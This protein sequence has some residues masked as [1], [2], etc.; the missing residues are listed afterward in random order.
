MDHVSSLSLLAFY[1]NPR[2]DSNA[3]LS[4]TEREEEQVTNNNQFRHSFTAQKS[5]NTGLNNVLIS[6]LP[7]IT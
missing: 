2:T 5:C 6:T 3:D 7:K 1:L 4:P